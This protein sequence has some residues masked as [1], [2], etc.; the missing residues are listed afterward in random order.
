MKHLRL[1]IAVLALSIAPLF[2]PTQ[3]TISAQTDETMQAEDSDIDQA[4]ED[5]GVEQPEAPNFT[6]P[7]VNEGHETGGYVDADGNP[8]SK[9]EFEAIRDKAE[10]GNGLSSLIIVAVGVA[11]LLVGGILIG[12][13]L[14]AKKAAPAAP[15]ASAPTEP[16]QPVEPTPPQDNP[17]QQPR[18]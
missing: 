16:A 8:I 14:G 6:E 3:S 10:E 1:L 15:V 13:K 7:T 18:V 17:D 12:K 2:I 4:L 5:A 11:V 9:E